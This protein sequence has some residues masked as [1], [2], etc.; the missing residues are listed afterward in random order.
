MTKDSRMTKT[1]P[2]TAPAI[3]HHDI[4]ALG[5]AIRTKIGDMVRALAGDDDIDY[6]AIQSETDRIVTKMTIGQ[7]FD[8]ALH[9][10]IVNDAVMTAERLAGHASPIMN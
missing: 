6:A 8:A 10:S 1:H 3:T 7:P 2:A 4:S 5:E 9:G